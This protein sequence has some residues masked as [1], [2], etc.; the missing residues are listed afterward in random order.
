MFLFF[1]TKVGQSQ[2]V[3][4][5]AIERLVNDPAVR[6][7]GLGV[8]VLDVKTG[9]TLGSYQ[10]Q[11]S[12]TPASSLKVVTTAS[13]LGI[14]GADFRFKTEL[15]Y[16]G[17][18][19]SE[20]TLNG[21]VYIKGYGD[22]T[23]GSDHFAKAVPLEKVLQMW[24]DALRQI[25]VKKINGRLVGD[26]SYF[27]TA[28][29]GRTWLWED[30]GNYYASGAWGLNIHENRYFIKFQQSQKLG[31][32]PKVVSTQP[33]IPNLLLLNEVESA[34]RG[35]GDNAYIFGAPFSYTRFI[36]GTIPV[37][38]KLFT[39][40]GSIPDPPFFAA[41]LLLNTLEAAGITTSK[42]ATS[43][44]ELD[45]LGVAKTKRATIHTHR[46][47][48]LRDIVKETNLKSVNLYCEAM[49]KLIGDKAKGERSTAAGVEAIPSFLERQRC[50]RRRI[51]YGRRQRP[52]ARQCR[53]CYAPGDYYAKDKIR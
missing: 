50:K 47:P 53:F 6:H 46:S 33:N 42:L 52:I 3:L 40:K 10:A 38:S 1:L 37:G 48:T 25:G 26:A 4:E 28:V 2:N 23:L 22:P 35:S 11:Q 14:L 44:F 12:L 13:A 31:S 9:Q 36:R 18:I 49:L 15:Q 32:T 7:A 41:H 21:N 24:V 51:F 43:Q 45:R 19:D 8:A 16:D 17:A 27:E 20:G 34:E 5:Q 39:I 30:L 29:N